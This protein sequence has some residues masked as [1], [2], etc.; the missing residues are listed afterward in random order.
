MWDVYFSQLTGKR[1]LRKQFVDVTLRL[2]ASQSAFIR[3]NFNPFTGQV[4]HVHRIYI[5]MIWIFGHD[6]QEWI[7]R[8]AIQTDE[9]KYQLNDSPLIA[10]NNEWF[11]SEYKW[12]Q[13]SHM[14]NGGAIRQ[15]S[16][17]W[18]SRTEQQR[19][20]GRINFIGPRRPFP[21][22]TFQPA[23]TNIS[24]RETMIDY[25]NVRRQRGSDEQMKAQ[26][27]TH[28]TSWQSRIEKPFGGSWTSPSG[29]Q[30]ATSSNKKWLLVTTKESTYHTHTHICADN[31]GFSFLRVCFCD[32]VGIL[33]GLM[34]LQNLLY[35][36]SK[37]MEYTDFAS[38]WGKGYTLSGSQAH[39]DIKFS[40]DSQ[41][42]E[43]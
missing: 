28:I 12:G 30:Y 35:K 2:L 34:P 23:P 43:K 15:I 41:W 18:S 21:S 38:T 19:L 13:R 6:N 26:K 37:P 16:K 8:T 17:Q 39:G 24:R 5:I 25:L 20:D 10:P 40:N 33:C 31:L 32:V 29:S 7:Q 11:R 22:V 1:F 3:L 42:C 36:D 27:K 9:K 14:C 4:D